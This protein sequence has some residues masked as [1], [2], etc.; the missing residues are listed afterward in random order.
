MT[1]PE[2]SRASKVR[3]KKLLTYVWSP[4]F[5]ASVT[6]FWTRPSIAGLMSASPQIS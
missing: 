5:D 3:P 4:K 6:K 2:G 1:M